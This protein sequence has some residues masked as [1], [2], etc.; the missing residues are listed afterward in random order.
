MYKYTAGLDTTSIRLIMKKELIKEL[1]YLTSAGISDCL[2]AL[3]ESNF[4]LQKA[5]DIVK[6]RGLNVVSGR[7]GKVAAEGA[8]A[9]EVCQRG[10]GMAEVNCQ[11]DFVA[12]SLGFQEFTKTVV[13]EFVN[14]VLGDEPFDVS[15][16]ENKRAAL[17]STTK[18]NIVVRR[19]WFEEAVSSAAEV[20]TYVH[21]N[22]K[23]GVLVTLL[24]PSEDAAKD[25]TFR[26]LGTDLAM[27]I[28]AMG[29]LAVSSNLLDSSEV[30]RQKAIFK[31]QLTQLNKQIAWPKILEG[32]FNKWYTKVCLMN[33]ES[34]THPKTTITQV[35]DNVAVKLGGKIQVV[36]FVR[37]QVGDGINQTKDVLADEVAKLVQ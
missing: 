16:V 31:T 6:S 5:V 21:H 1:R 15:I 3:K 30:E 19:W 18:E 25:P 13:I 24:A 20:F 35:I 4:D 8:V 22:N 9:I 28:A 23:I 7:E 36:N 10:A 32:K 14:S 17:I 34:I 2:K 26:E 27:Q 33:Q 12:N 37:C 11:T 29:P